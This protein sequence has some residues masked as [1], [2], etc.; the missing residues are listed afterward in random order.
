MLCVECGKPVDILIP[1]IVTY[2]SPP[3]NSHVPARRKKEGEEE[4][5]EERGGRG[6]NGDRESLGGLR[7]LGGGEKEP[8]GTQKRT[9]SLV[10]ASCAH[11]AQ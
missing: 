10:G 5:K 7:V 8:Q 2:G 6:G 4:E 3:P 1:N 9:T 11:Y